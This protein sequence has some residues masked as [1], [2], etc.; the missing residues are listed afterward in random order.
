MSND[1]LLKAMIVIGAGK[2][3]PKTVAIQA[4]EN[5]LEQP[6]PPRQ[7]IRLTDEEIKRLAD[8]SLSPDWTDKFELYH[9]ARD[10]EAALVEKN[11]A[12]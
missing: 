1:E 2:G 12:F 9:F 4:L 11:N 8:S 3:D 7:F 5:Y 6:M 10:I